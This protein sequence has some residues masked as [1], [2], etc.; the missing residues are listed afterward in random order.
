MKKLHD[1]QA[2]FTVLKLSKFQ[3]NLMD[4]IEDKVLLS[5]HK[6]QNAYFIFTFFHRRLNAVE[7]K[8]QTHFDK[9]N[10]IDQFW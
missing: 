2:F 3:D 1:C 10:S 7:V 5:K 9:P 4:L 6:L 8:L